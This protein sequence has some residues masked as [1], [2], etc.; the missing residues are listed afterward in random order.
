MIYIDCTSTYSINT[1]TGIQRVVRNILDSYVADAELSQ[2]VQPIVYTSRGFVPV[3][4]LQSH[5]YS[6]GNEKEKEE[7][8]QLVDLKNIFSIQNIK[9]FLQ[10]LPFLYKVAKFF[11]FYMKRFLASKKEVNESIIFTKDDTILFL[12]ATW[13]LP[14]W[15][16]LNT[17]KKSESKI[18]F[19]IYDLIPIY[20]SQFC[21]VAHREDFEKFFV[22]SLDFADQ[23]I[24]ISQTVI[25]DV[26]KYALTTKHERLN[27]IKY[28][29]FYLGSDFTKN[30]QKEN[31]RTKIVNFFTGNT[32]VFLTVS[33]I[34]P[35]KNHKFILEA[36]DKL[37]DSNQ[38]VKLCFI[39][40]EGW[41]VEKFM[42]KIKN[43]KFLNDKFFVLHDANDAELSYAYQNSRSLVFASFVEGFGL[44]IIESLNLKLPV[45]A[46]DIPIHKEVGGTTADYF[47]LN[48]VDMLIKKINYLKDN[49]KEDIDFSWL[50]WDK[51]SKMLF[52]KVSTGA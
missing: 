46:S 35:R 49:N 25:D 29:Y 16:D 27:E 41:K 9:L 22:K 52:E 10:R 47:D 24:G 31:V 23:Y 26:K 3:E 28:D 44:P 34:E 5:E 8:K 4:N 15:D 50:D 21:N 11:Y 45:L 7:K 39:G 40:K 36:F 17:I 38:D 42:K 37:W 6:T 48:S 2:K 32:P 30:S 33:T 13:N 18:V 1:M 14:I 51:S 19:V 20:Y 12:D 43:H